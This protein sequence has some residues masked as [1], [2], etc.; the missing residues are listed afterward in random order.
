MDSLIVN[1]NL[2]SGFA[3]LKNCA[4]HFDGS[5]IIKDVFNM[6][7]LE[8]KHYGKDIKIYDAKNC[9]VTP[10]LIDSHLHGIGGFGTEDM[11]AESILGMSLALADCGVTGFLPT[12][13]T[14][15]MEDMI[16]SIEAIKNAMGRERGARILGINV[17]GPFIS[18]N[19][20]G[21]QPA[22]C[23]KPVDIEL[24]D[25][26]MDAG[27]G[28]IVC[29]TVAPELKGMRELALHA[30]NRG[31]ILLAGHTDA[32]YE[33]FIEGMQ[34]G[35]LHTTH[36]FNAMKGLHHRNPGAV[37]AVLI[38]NDISCEVIADGIHVHPELVKLIVK[39]KPEENIVLVTDSLKPT[40]Q[41]SGDLMV[42]GEKALLDE[43]GVFVKASDHSILFGSA[44]TLNKA[45][46]NLCEWGI[47]TETAVRMASE[48]PARIYNFAKLGMILPG[49][50]ADI[51]IFDS[52]F[53]A[54]AVFIGGKPVVENL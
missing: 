40:N 22:D 25:R 9:I 31:V 14:D 30:R 33:N 50:F 2:S 7:R 54:K 10:G 13:F 18:P 38:Q 27:G 47:D 52:E 49:N 28:K 51:S 42:N 43:E 3:T 11:K 48:N 4:I 5:G 24:F 32:S 35:I 19:R 8:S 53:N 29:M 36:F 46:A 39:L 37:G 21:A 15:K 12:V 16:K 34:C 17:E 44:L 45:V 41:E 1:A 6:S 26:L 23:C 20:A